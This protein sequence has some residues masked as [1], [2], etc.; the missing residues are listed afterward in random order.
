MKTFQHSGT[1]IFKISA[2]M[3]ELDSD[4]E[5][6]RSDP[7]KLKVL[8]NEMIQMCLWGNATD[9]SLL[10]HLS[11]DDIC[12]LQSVGKDAQAARK[13]FILKDDQEAVWNHLQSLRGDRIDFVLDNC[14][15]LFKRPIYY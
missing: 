15:S 1:S 5:G 6:L 7:E 9:L 13:Q 11:Q 14:A 12:H 10:T 2:I 8:F 4:K 3:N